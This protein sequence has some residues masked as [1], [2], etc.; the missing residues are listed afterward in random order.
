MSGGVVWGDL[1]RGVDRRRT[2][3]A[4]WVYS[5]NQFIGTTMAGQA[6]FFLTSAGL[7]TTASFSIN[8]G[9]QGI[10]IFG[11]I[12]GWYLITKFSRRAVYIGGMGAILVLLIIVGILGCIQTSAASN[13]SWGVGGLLM[14]YVCINDAAVASPN[15]AIITEMSSVRLRAK[16][17]A[18][19]R[20]SYNLCGLIISIFWPYMIN[21]TALNWGAKAAFFWCGT[22][23]FA[24]V[25]LVSGT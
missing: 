12:I 2:A 17:V 3:L 13:T 8:L 16:T 14:L 19:A 18:L 7:A 10:G 24:M 23:V 6:T 25:T 22:T 9:I 20:M 21:T 5:T 15:Y 1:F 11:C 4:C